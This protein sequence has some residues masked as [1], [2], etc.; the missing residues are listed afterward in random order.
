MHRNPKMDSTGYPVRSP[1]PASSMCNLHVLELQV[2][3]SKRSHTLGYDTLWWSRRFSLRKFELK[4]PQE[5]GISDTA[6]FFRITDIEPQ[7]TVHLKILCENWFWTPFAP[8][9][10]RLYGVSYLITLYSLHSCCSN[11][12][13]LVQSFTIVRVIQWIV[14][15][16]NIS[17]VVMLKIQWKS[18]VY[19]DLQ[20]KKLS[21]Q[22]VFPQ[23]CRKEKPLTS[24]TKHFSPNIGNFSWVNF[25]LLQAGL[26]SLLFGLSFGFGF[27][28]PFSWA[29][30]LCFKV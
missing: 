8:G 10:I 21:K 17:A 27:R 18:L 11:I 15:I 3:S 22:S 20:L 12:A 28:F 13:E 6:Y 29:S 7:P 25:R 19:K 1:T 30:K 2:K 23:G 16:I 24:S 4:S 26:G 14:S 5:H 9:L